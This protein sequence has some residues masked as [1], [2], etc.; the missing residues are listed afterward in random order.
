VSTGVAFLASAGQ[1]EGRAATGDRWLRE[2]LREAGA[3]VVG[4]R[5]VDDGTIISSAGA[6]AGIDLAL[7]LLERYVGPA[8]AQAVERRLEYERRGTV[9]RRTP[10]LLR[11]QPP[12]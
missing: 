12:S 1:L 11:D 2:S 8:A 4:A 7:W 5:V 9:W 10:T 3:D 6:T